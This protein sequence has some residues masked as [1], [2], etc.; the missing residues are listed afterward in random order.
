M[1]LK[2]AKFQTNMNKAQKQP[3][4]WVALL[5][6]HRCLPIPWVTWGAAHFFCPHDFWH[7]ITINKAEKKFFVLGRV[8]PIVRLRSTRL[9]NYHLVIIPY[10]SIIIFLYYCIMQFCK[11]YFLILSYS[12]IILLSYLYIFLLLY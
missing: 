5:C 1:T 9:C 10:C 2:S 3:I 8:L 12:Y 4:R 11:L 7:V 6:V